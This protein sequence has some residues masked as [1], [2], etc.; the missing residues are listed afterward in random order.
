MPHENGVSPKNR[1]FDYAFFRK[2][3][4]YFLLLTVSGPVLTRRFPGES[5]ENAI[6]L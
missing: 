4:Y 5:F 1:D 2:K 3:S 6:E